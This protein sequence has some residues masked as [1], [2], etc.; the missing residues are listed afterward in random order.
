MKTGAYTDTISN[1]NADPVLKLIAR[2]AS[3]RV[4]LERFLPMLKRGQ[5]KIAP[6]PREI[7]AKLRVVIP[8][9]Q[10]IG[11]CFVTEG[12]TGTIF[13]DYDSPIGV[14]A[15]FMVHEIAHALEPKVW[16]GKTAKSQAAMLEAEE[17]AF[18]TQFKFTQELRERD[19]EY[20]TFLKTHYPK[21]KL[22]HTLLEFEDI[23]ELYRKPA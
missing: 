8:E 21:A 3:G 2:T 16:A 10:P 7:V 15:P 9:G 23:E 5:V 1:A 4:L 19:P 13:I 22:L 12:A 6:Y 18:Q 20:D 11:A 17:S 14:L